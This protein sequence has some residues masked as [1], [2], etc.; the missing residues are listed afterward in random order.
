VGEPT[1]S[2]APLEE[3]GLNGRYRWPDEGPAAPTGVCPHC[4]HP[5][6]G[7]ISCSCS[8]DGFLG[9]AAIGSIMRGPE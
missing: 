3:I 6:D 1:D 5:L 2:P 7:A 8:K 9:R 4:E